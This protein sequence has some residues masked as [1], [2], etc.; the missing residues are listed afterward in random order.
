MRI[1]GLRAATIGVCAFFALSGQASGQQSAVQRSEDWIVRG[2]ALARR[3]EA[4]NLIVTAHTRTDRQ[5]DAAHAQGEDRLQILY[6]LAADDYVGSD[7]EAG[8]QSLAA[9]RREAAAQRDT[10][11]LAMVTMLEAYRPALDGDYVAARRNLTRA[12]GATDD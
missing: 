7:A 1:P 8:A 11:Y 3:I 5:A 12:L 10:H 6:D 9:F 2:E 4:G